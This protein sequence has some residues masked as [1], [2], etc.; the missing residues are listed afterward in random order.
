[1]TDNCISA[2]MSADSVHNLDLTTLKNVQGL[3]PLPNSSTS[4]G[5]LSISKKAAGPSIHVISCRFFSDGVR[6]QAD[7]SL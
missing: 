7:E 2:T 4:Y 1:M 5:G 6:I 3:G